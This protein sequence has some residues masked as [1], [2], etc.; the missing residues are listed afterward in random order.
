MFS[1]NTL[2]NQLQRWHET[3]CNQPQNPNAYI[4]RGMVYF[5]LAKIHESIQDFDTAQKLDPRL[6]P[7]L[8][9][10]GLSYYYA[11]KFAEGAQQFEID[12]TVNAQDVEETVWRYL[13]IARLRGV[14][15]ARNSLLTVKN[16]PRRIMRCVYDLYA[17][18][19]SPDDVLVVG[20]SEGEKGK[21]YSHLYVGLY[22]EAE[23]N[24]D[25]A[26]E[27]IVKAA[28]QYK[29]DDYMWYLARVHKRM[30]EKS[31]EV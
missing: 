26:Q 11:G 14:T 18:N 4:H 7:Y 8:W 23:N 17:G 6:T 21:F 5:Q 15:E 13:C 16:D 24:L 25:L 2:E 22:Y 28:D 10:R 31:Q 9:Q 20:Q 3:I 12:L 1:A 19:C 30:L 27:Y 29:I